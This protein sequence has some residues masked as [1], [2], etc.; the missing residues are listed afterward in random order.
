MRKKASG[1]N[2]LKKKPFCFEKGGKQEQSG[3]LG[4]CVAFIFSGNGHVKNTILFLWENRRPILNFSSP[5]ISFFPVTSGC[6]PLRVQN[7]GSCRHSGSRYL[8]FICTISCRIPSFTEERP[9]V[10]CKG[11]AVTKENMI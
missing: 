6:L 4:K 5:P 11:K 3:G 8:T 1:I 10:Q 9:T 7:M 2:Q